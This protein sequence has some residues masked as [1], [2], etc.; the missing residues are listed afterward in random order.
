MKVFRNKTAM[1]FTKHCKHVTELYISKWLKQ[2]SW[3]MFAAA[4]AAKSLQSCPT[5]CDPIDGSPPGYPV[6]GFLQAR[7]LEWVAISFSRHMFSHQKKKKKHKLVKKK[8]KKNK[9]RQENGGKQITVFFIHLR[10]KH[11]HIHT[12]THTLMCSKNFR[13]LQFSR[14]LP[15]PELYHD[16][17]F[18]YISKALVTR[19]I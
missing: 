10:N 12:H 14:V 4:A 6:P 5:L 17:K 11:I 19:S 1:M 15:S 9:G 3:H 2:K 18:K 7:T 13:Q 16:S 8:K